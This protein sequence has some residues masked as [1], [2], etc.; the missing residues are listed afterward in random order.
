MRR[1]LARIFPGQ[2]PGYGW[3]TEATGLHGARD[4]E[5]RRAILREASAPVAERVDSLAARI[6]QRHR[7][8]DRLEREL[9]LRQAPPPSSA[10]QRQLMAAQ[11][12]EP[13][14]FTNAQQERIH[15]LSGRTPTYWEAVKLM[16]LR[17]GW[18]TLDSFVGVPGKHEILWEG[19][20]LEPSAGDG[21]MLNRPEMYGLIK[22]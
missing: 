19:V 6:Q 7:E 11:C 21:H 10:R 15:A 12:P 3:P 1:L 8:V 2:R 13:R 22:P 14:R 20:R 4:G 5:R 17:P 18:E 9:S 16:G